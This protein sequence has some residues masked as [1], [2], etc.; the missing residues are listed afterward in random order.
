M[1]PANND[2]ASDTAA[3]SRSIA[4]KQSSHDYLTRQAD[5]ARHAI[6]CTLR[7]LCCAA[8]DV[9]DVRL[10]TRQFPWAATGSAALIGFL[11]ARRAM[12]APGSPP[13]VEEARND[14]RRLPTEEH[15]RLAEAPVKQWLRRVRGEL[16]RSV[17]KAVLGFI[18]AKVG[19][20]I[21]S[22]GE[23]GHDPSVE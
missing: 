19:S 11:A 3:T 6:A 15:V 7:E 21:Q 20:R 2:N 8:E 17:Q 12:R 22:S 10:W 5:D 14:G 13:P 18:A 16:V 9:A 4:A 1:K 23:N